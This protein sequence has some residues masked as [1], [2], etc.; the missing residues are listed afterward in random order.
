M[1]AVMWILGVILFL[2]LFVAGWLV[3]LELVE[4]YKLDKEIKEVDALWRSLTMPVTAVWGHGDRIGG[5]RGGTAVRRLPTLPA[6]VKRAAV[7]IAVAA[8]VLW[9]LVAA[10][11]PAG[12][13]DDLT[14]A[15]GNP[16]TV[17]SSAQRIFDTGGAVNPA[18]EGPANDR[19]GSAG[20][21]ATEGRMVP[22]S[23]AAQ[24]R[25][26]TAIRVVWGHVPSAIEY[27]VERSKG[28]STGAWRTIAMVEQNAYI[29]DELAAATTYFYRIT[30]VTPGGDAPPSDIVSATTPIAV[31]PATT[32]SGVPALDTVA[33]AWA[34][35][36]GETGYRIERSLDGSTDWKVVGTQGQDVTTFIDTKLTPGTSYHYRVIATNAGGESAPSN[37]FDATTEIAPIEEPPADDISPPGGGDVP[38]DVGA[39]PPAEGGLAGDVPLGTAVDGAL[40]GVLAVDGASLDGAAVGGA[41][42]EGAA[43]DAAA[44]D[45]AA[46]LDVVP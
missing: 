39:A 14:S 43:V 37:V 5:R 36:A 24:P 19:T 20:G 25:S 33:L 27:E 11:N 46:V 10:P 40:G 42:V 6:P 41:T 3:A 28:V 17:P 31:P 1:D 9:V 45:E 7:P 8:T 16:V 12:E 4:R 21:G 32:L 26:S 35:V 22:V 18:R 44:T 13:P 34:D 38:T 23:V 30:A 29:D 2:N 15:Q